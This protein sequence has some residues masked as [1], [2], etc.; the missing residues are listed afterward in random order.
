MR[1][2]ASAAL[3]LT[4]VLVLAP[5]SVSAAPLT[6]GHVDLDIDF[7]SGA[8]TLDWKTYTPSDDDLPAAGSPVSVPLANAYVVPGT[9]SFACLGAAGSTVYRLK[10][11]QD[12][13]QVWLGYN[14]QN[15]PSGVFTNDKVTLTLKSVVSAPPSGRFVLYTT[16]AFGTPTYLLNSTSGSCNRTSLTLSHNIHA[17]A[18]WAFSSPGT[19]VLRFEARGALSAGGMA[20]SGDVDVTFTVP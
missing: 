6:S 13:T 16:S 3:A 19:Y 17:H 20:S 1:T 12:A 10:Q 18:W 9:A 11:A 7:V 15:V 5:A 14:T 4:L 8:L 2:R